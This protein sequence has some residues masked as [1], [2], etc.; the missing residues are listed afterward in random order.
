[1]GNALTQ[2]TGLSKMQAIKS[3][4]KTLIDIGTYVFVFVILHVY[5]FICICV[6]IYAKMNMHM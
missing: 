2:L 4:L 1:M 5:T 3:E 6:N